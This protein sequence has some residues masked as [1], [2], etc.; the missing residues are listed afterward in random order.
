MDDNKDIIKEKD[1]EEKDDEEKLEDVMDLES[2][3]E[4]ENTPLGRSSVGNIGKEAAT[5]TANAVVFADE[6]ANEMD[7]GLKNDL[8]QEKTQ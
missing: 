1:D 3:K 5:R 7:K 8:I 2:V 4:N 6:A